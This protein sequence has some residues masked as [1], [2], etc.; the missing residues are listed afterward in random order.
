MP[1]DTRFERGETMQQRIA[2][3]REKIEALSRALVS[4]DVR[5]KI[6]PQGAVAF[7]G[8]AD[9]GPVSDACA[10]RKLMASGS[11]QAKLAIQ[12]AETLAGRTIN[13]QTV[14]HGVHSHDGGKTWHEGH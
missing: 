7:E 3:V 12:R 9:R 13:N 4:G 2:T 10:Y 1:C 8:W 11:A 6:G 5:V 14:A